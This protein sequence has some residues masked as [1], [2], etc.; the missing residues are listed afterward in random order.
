VPG[1]HFVRIVGTLGMQLVLACAL[2]VALGCDKG[3]LLTGAP[4][5]SR[6]RELIAAPPVTDAVM[7]RF[8]KVARHISAALQDPAIRLELSN[9]LKS[10][11]RSAGIDLQDCGHAGVADHLFDS[12]EVQGAGS[13]AA[14]CELATKENGLVLFMD[15]TQLKAWDPTVTPIVTAVERPDQLAMT[16]TLQGYRS[17]TT[18]IELNAG[19][20]NVGPVL[21]IF[22]HVHPNRAHSDPRQDKIVRSEGHSRGGAH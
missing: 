4:N 22:P 17:P 15:R 6:A 3:P 12:G 1:N 9:A 8:S 13:A 10:D 14:L 11:P 2:T 16:A 18:M 19:D 20:P 21:V 5:S 7:G